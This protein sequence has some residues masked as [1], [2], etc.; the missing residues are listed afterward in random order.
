[1]LVRP[2]K[3]TLVPSTT[4]SPADHARERRGV[5]RPQRVRSAPARP[6]PPAPP[7]TGGLNPHR[8]IILVAVLTGAFLELLDTTSVNVAL[9]QI[10]GNLGATSDEVAW[11]STGYILSNVV[12][13]PMTA[14][15]ASVF[16]RRRYLT[17]SILLFTFASILCGLSGTL[18][19]LVFWRI[20][21]GAGGAA[22]L[23]TAQASLSEV[24]PKEQQ[25]L[26]QALFIVV[27][28]AG[29]TLG[30]AF[31]GWVTD[32]YSWQWIFLAKSPLGL[33]AAA[34]I[35]RFL[36]DSQ[37]REKPRGL[38]WQGIGLLAVG[39]GSLQ[40]VLEEG[41]RY[42]WFDDPAITR[43]AVLAAGTLAAFVAWELSPA[44]TRAVVSL[45][46]L[47]HRD[48]A[49]GSL[50]LMVSGVGIY[51]GVFILPLFVQGVL[52]FSPTETGLLFLPAGVAT[53]LGTVACGLLL[54]GARPLVKPPALIAAGF[55]LFALSQSLLG[56]LTP[57]SGAGDVQAG[58]ILRGAGLGLLLTPVTVAA[59][60]PLRGAEIAQGAGLTNLFRQLGGS[61]GIALV[62]TYVTG[63][64]AR[65]RAALVLHLYA[66]NPILDA[67][68]SGTA[69]RFLAAGLS[70]AGAHAAAVAVLDRLVQRQ[71]ATLAYDDA[72]LLLAAVS[73]VSVPV[74]LLL[75]HRRTRSAPAVRIR[76]GH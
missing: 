24:F 47:R 3:A 12:I 14:W 54:N 11:I 23:S 43:L 63:Q 19:A 29:P 45:R 61:F 73:A 51:G 67:R 10:Q 5:E 22:L 42:D 31:G 34:L 21:Q 30:P 13:L 33:G 56:H 53:I 28:V 48:L 15:L 17:A 38:D 62:N 64:A 41:E 9:R 55:G 57:Q 16:G 40:Y 75:V 25:G 58:L 20:V 35:W 50:L 32:N 26:I 18:G 65:H 46:V 44:N 8:W 60:S 2:D 27:V 68:V 76:P 59:L 71:A 74:A 1:M 36:A 6:L 39:L 72:F 7:A 70:P 52:G 37:I 66:G 49:V 4:T 69:A